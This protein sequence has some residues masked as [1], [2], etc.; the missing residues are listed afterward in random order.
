MS[1]YSFFRDGFQIKTKQNNAFLSPGAQINL[2]EYFHSSLI[3]YPLFFSDLRLP[4]V[5][6]IAPA[7]HTWPPH[8]ISPHLYSF[9]HSIC[10]IAGAGH[11]VGCGPVEHGQ[12][13]LQGPGD[14]WAGGDFG[15]TE[16]T[17][18][19]SKILVKSLHSTC[20]GYSGVLG[21]DYS[22]AKVGGGGGPGPQGTWWGWR[23]WPCLLLRRALPKD[24][25]KRP[26]YQ[27]TE[28]TNWE[29]YKW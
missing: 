14:G 22:W 5:P 7:L 3:K 15:N 4:T 2:L 26:N 9:R 11:E 23:I 12:E 18:N 24:E 27:E 28:G 13:A 21:W 16:V 20:D 19:C 1:S 25:V 17:E 29:L 8:Y 10:R 6:W